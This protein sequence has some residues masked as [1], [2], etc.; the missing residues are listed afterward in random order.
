MINMLKFVSVISIF[1]TILFIANIMY[2][3]LQSQSY[4]HAQNSSVQ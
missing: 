3:E 2:M 1:I 4:V